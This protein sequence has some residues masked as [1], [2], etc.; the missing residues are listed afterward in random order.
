M[1]WLYL[2]FVVV[3]L[4]DADAVYIQ[5]IW[6]YW[7]HLV[8]ICQNLTI[9]HTIMV[10]FIILCHVLVEIHH[11]VKH[12]MSKKMSRNMSIMMSMSSWIS[13]LAWHACQEQNIRKKLK[14]M[15]I[16]SAVM[17]IPVECIAYVLNSIVWAWCLTKTCF[18]DFLLTFWFF[19]KTT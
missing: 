10:Y 4:C 11:I 13:A 1:A 15:K 5:N 6:N 18:F 8:L 2:V 14:N 17:F 3:Y 7:N 16:I 12:G 19:Y 9:M